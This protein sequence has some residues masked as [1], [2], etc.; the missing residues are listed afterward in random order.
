MPLAYG[1]LPGNS[2]AL[3]TDLFSALDSFG[4][5]D[6]QSVLCDYEHALLNAIVN[7]WPSFTL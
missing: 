7:T 6:T 1:L 2:E 5:Y 4:Q 3:Y